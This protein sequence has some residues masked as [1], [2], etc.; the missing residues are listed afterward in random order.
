[1]YALILTNSTITQLNIQHSYKQGKMYAHTY[2]MK[3]HMSLC[4]HVFNILKQS[5]PDCSRRV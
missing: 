1:M 4:Q 5:S 3:K 2:E